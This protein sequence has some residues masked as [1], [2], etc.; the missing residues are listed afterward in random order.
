MKTTFSVILLFL[1]LAGVMAQRSAVLDAYIQEGLARNIGLQQQ[2]KVQQQALERVRQAD[3]LRLPSVGFS[4]YYSL[5]A[6]G[7]TLEFP[8]GDLL[9]PVYS[10]LNDLTGTNN[11]PTIENVSE[12]FLP[13]DFQQTNLSVQYP[14]FNSDIRH[15]RD[16]QRNLAESQNAQF[17]AQA[18]DLRYRITEA[19]LRYLQTLEAEKIWLNTKEV[20]NE[21][22]DFNQSLVR[23]NVATKDVVATADYEISKADNELYK[24]RSQQS[25]VRAYFNQLL[26]RDLQAPVI[27]DSILLD[28]PADTFATDTL[29]AYALANR[30][31]F[32][33]L[34]SGMD[35]ADGN[36]RLLE[37]RIRMPKAYVGGEL[38]FQGFGYDIFD[39]Q[40]YAFARVG[41]TYDIFQGGVRSSQSQEARLEKERLSLQYTELEQQVA[42][43][44]TQRYNNL[45]AAYQTWQT[46]RRG[47][48]SAEEIF[49]I[50]TNKYRAGNQLLIEWLDAQNRVTSAQLQV[51]VSYADLLIEE[52][53]LKAAIGL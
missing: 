44:V 17:N 46:S 49:R 29:I 52:T 24:I 30:Q 38:G 3:G 42:L 18:N 21:L 15:N 14:L 23:N 47:L 45:V 41:L 48:A 4:A 50:S 22:R 33:A 9:N 8:V 35:A 25:S 12:Q 40:A 53:R 5:A 2:A 51:L 10:T 7:R 26:N 43:Q 34:R 28:L 19:Y 13:N 20:L 36:L 37:S 31:E 11:F 32:S 16:I 39:G 1:P 6:G 27:A